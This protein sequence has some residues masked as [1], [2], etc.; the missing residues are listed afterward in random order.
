MCVALNS[1]RP[2]EAY[3]RQ[4]I[5]HVIVWLAV[6]AV[7]NH[8]LKQ[9]WITVNWNLEWNRNRN[10]SISCKKINWCVKLLLIWISLINYINNFSID[11]LNYFNGIRHYAFL[12][13]SLSFRHGSYMNRDNAYRNVLSYKHIWQMPTDFFPYK[14]EWLKC[15]IL[16]NWRFLLDFVIVFQTHTHSFMLLI[17]CTAQCPPSLRLNTKHS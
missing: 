10:T 16:V 17:P 12:M 1:S 9:W 5:K 6:Y 8:H 15:F 4:K 11:A 2:S 13:Q 3:M 7:P 14:P